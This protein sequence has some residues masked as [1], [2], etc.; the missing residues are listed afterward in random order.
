VQHLGESS[1]EVAVLRLLG[2]FDRPADEGLIAVLREA[3]EPGL[4]A[5]NV[6]LRCLSPAD[7]RR[8]LRRLTDLRLIDVSASPAPPIDSHP[9]L[10]EYFVE[11]L[12]THFPDA[13]RTG[14]RWLFEH[15]CETTEHQP[16]TLAGLQPLYQA[17]VHGC[18][19]G[20]Y[21]QALIDIYDERILR[22]TGLAGFYSTV[23]L[24]AIGANLTVVASF[25]IAPWTALTPSLALSEQ[26]WLLNDAACSLRALGRLT[27]AIEPMRAG[28]KKRILEKDWF[29]AAISAGNLSEL[30][31]LRGGVSAAVIA[32]E[33]SVE[34]ANRTG[35][36]T[37]QMI[38]RTTLANALHQAGRRTEAR[39]LFEAA[40]SLQAAFQSEY[41]QLYSQGGFLYCD[42]L[43][44]DAERAAWQAYLLIPQTASTV[45]CDPVSE[46][47]KGAQRAWRELFINEE[48]LLDIALDHL[49]LARST[50]YK[51][52]S[53][54]SIPQSALNHGNTAVT[55]LRASGQM[56]FL[57]SGLLTRAWL[58]RL[59]GD[60]SGCRGDLAEAWEIAERGPMPLF[61]ADIQLY[62]ARLFRD[63]AAL[64]EARR[65]IEKHGYHR[66]DEELA[67][68]EIAAKRWPETATSKL[69]QPAEPK[70]NEGSMRDQIFISYSHKDK[71]LMGELLTHLE[72]YLRSGSVEGWCDRDIVSGSKWFD[73]LQ[74]A[75]SKTSV[76]I[77]LVSPDFL[78]SDFIHHH[79]LTPLLKEAESG[80]VKILWVQIRASAYE[81][82]SL[83]NYQAVVSPPDKPLGAKSK[84]D[85]DEAWVQVC[86][87]IKNAVN[88]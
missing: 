52:H 39:H 77:L 14:H 13:W 69:S 62:R 38:S 15:L 70:T 37:Q 3:Q 71:K 24:G 21:H 87:V 5:L 73:E 59:S 41:T 44:S 54:L 2:F 85:R 34:Y 22:G 67:D 64:D 31:L 40:E 32:G 80:G 25:F 27:E 88:P 55:N 81:E 60:K 17:V 4:D 11:Q 9:L 57:P 30:E 61:Q 51:A 28:L 48:S 50:L 63:R 75:L 72:P 66:R 26:A 74:A 83:K 8:V 45:A 65:L 23:R 16:A 43:L 76:A 53:V 19:A 6:P 18:L 42:L 47:A 33:Q 79:E 35:G 84:A 82:T 46:R 10:R 68:A 20:L 1:P 78:A 58:C 12:R 29:N 86:K 7:W 56:D 49:T 36:A